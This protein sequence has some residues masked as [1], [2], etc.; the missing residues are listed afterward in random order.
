MIRN[1]EEQSQ[2]LSGKATEKG[3]Y[4]VVACITKPCC[5]H[6]FAQTIL[7]DWIVGRIV[8]VDGLNA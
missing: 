4:S 3:E 5:R 7:K 2:F 6:I 8:D 1:R